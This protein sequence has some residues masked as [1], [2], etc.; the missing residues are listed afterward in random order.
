MDARLIKLKGD[1]NNIITVRTSVKNIFDI[2]QIRINKL[3]IFYAEF[4]KDSKNDMFIFGLDSFHFQSKLI[5]IEYDDMK[6]LFLAINNRM[7][8]EYF[9]LYKII[10]EYIV[11]NIPDKKVKDNI[12]VNNYPVYKDL[13]PYKEYKFET[14]QDIHENILNFI[15]ILNS[16]LS[17]KENELLIHKSKQSIGLNIDNFI[18]TFNYNINVIKEKIN[19]FVSYI[20]FFHKMHSKYLKRFSNKIQLMHTHI[21]SDIR[22]DENL[23]LS[24]H[25]K[26]ELIASLNVENVNNMLLNDLKK[27]MN[28]DT[29]SDTDNDTKIEDKNEEESKSSTPIVKSNSSFV[30]FKEIIKSNVNKMSNILHICNTTDTINPNMSYNEMSTVF[31]NIESSCDAIINSEAIEENKAENKAE[32]KENSESSEEIS[33]VSDYSENLVLII[34]TNDDHVNTFIPVSGK[35]IAEA[36]EDVLN[37]LK[38]LMDNKSREREVVVVPVPEPTH[39]QEQV[40]KQV[41]KIEEKLEQ[42]QEQVELITNKKKKKKHKK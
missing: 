34:N 16:M 6:R 13:E 14:I 3:K 5:D 20:E 39:K 24:K 41:Q 31:S 23:E 36:K 10:T 27:S 2:L 12:K 7:Y 28:S 17:N 35:H 21:D 26:K 19:M 8:C 37:E 33:E 4:I 1:F 29:S 11:K 38:E 9:K 18:T 30:N 32:S 22:F 25:K 15:S 42:E 40:L